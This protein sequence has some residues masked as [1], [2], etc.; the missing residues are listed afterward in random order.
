[1]LLHKGRLPPQFVVAFRNRLVLDAPN[2]IR[3]ESDNE[4]A[5]QFSFDVE[6]SM[7]RYGEL[8]WEL[9]L[10]ARVEYCY[11]Y[12]RMAR[13][14]LNGAL[15]LDAGCGNGTLS[16]ALAASG[17]EVVVYGLDYSNSVE[18]AECNKRRFA[19]DATDRVH[20]VQGDVQHPPFA[21]DSFDVVYSDG[22][23][24]HTPSTR[25]SFDALAPLVKKAGRM[26][27][28]VY[29][30]DLRPMYQ[31]KKAMVDIIRTLLRP[32]PLM[33][34]RILCFW[35][36]IVLIAQLRLQHLF[37][38]RSRRII[39]VWLKAVNLFDTF[40]PRYNYQHT[41]EEVKS[42]FIDAGFPHP[43]ETTLPNLG[44][45]GFGILGVREMR[46]Y[47]YRRKGGNGV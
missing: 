28:W 13:G 3:L 46:D 11:R 39:P 19:G 41:P 43:V 4:K 31:L 15:V 20:Y 32:L 10:S 25:L 7:Y 16:A 9:D 30:S 36:A 35:G 47:L 1:M 40:T 6:W 17:P 12:L 2:L 14:A 23:L 8:T 5:K 21:K 29:R 37:G 42:W 18:H 22:V 33:A 44:Q 45:M 34:V 26:F 24:H 38:F 27:V